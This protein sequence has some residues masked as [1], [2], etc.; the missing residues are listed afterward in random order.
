L[1]ISANPVVSRVGDNL[2]SCQRMMQEH[3]IRRLGAYPS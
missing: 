1:A 2:D 3:Q